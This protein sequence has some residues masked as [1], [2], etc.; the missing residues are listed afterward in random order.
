MNLPSF[1]LTST[2]TNGHNPTIMLSDQAA[3]D[4]GTSGQS[5]KA[6]TSPGRLALGT[7]FTRRLAA[8]TSEGCRLCLT[9]AIHT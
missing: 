4:G 6:T 3:I 2:K 7:F 5:E 8:C 1:I 9:V